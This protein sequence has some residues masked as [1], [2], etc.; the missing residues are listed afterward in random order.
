ME[1]L[2]APDMITT[3]LAPPPPPNTQTSLR[4][5]GASADIMFKCGGHTFPAHQAVICPQS[6]KLQDT[7]DATAKVGPPHIQF[8]EPRPD[9]D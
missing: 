2:T 9:Q 3:T 1:T 8:H 5:D 6:Q 4:H 7:C